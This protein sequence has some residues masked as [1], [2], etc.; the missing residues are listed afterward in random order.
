MA[1]LRFNGLSINIDVTMGGKVEIRLRDGRRYLGIL[2]SV[3]LPGG[4]VTFH[5]SGAV[6]QLPDQAWCRT[7]QRPFEHSTR[8]DHYHQQ[9]WLGEDGGYLLE[10]FCCGEQVRL[11]HRGRGPAWTEVPEKIRPKEGQVVAS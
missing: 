4:A 6:M 3:T 1:N 8:L 7:F 10:C 5:L 11:Y 9:D 2:D